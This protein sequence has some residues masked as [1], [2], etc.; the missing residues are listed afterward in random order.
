MLGSHNRGELLE[1]DRIN[2]VPPAHIPGVHRYRSRLKTRVVNRDESLECGL[3]AVLSFLPDPVSYFLTQPWLQPTF[4]VIRGAKVAGPR[5]CFPPPSAHQRPREIRAT[6]FLRLGG[7][8]TS[9]DTIAMI[10]SSTIFWRTRVVK[11]CWA[12]LY[13]LGL[14]IAR[15]CQACWHLELGTR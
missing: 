15:K 10:G 6:I 14:P 9:L 5:L 3:G 11:T 4:Q 8:K 7:M 1:G 12:G 13:I 2:C